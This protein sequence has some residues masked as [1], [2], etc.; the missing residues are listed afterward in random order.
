MPNLNTSHC[1]LCEGV[2]CSRFY[3]D[4]NKRRFLICTQCQLVYVMPEYLPCKEFELSEYQLHENSIQDEGY[5][6]FLQR[7]LTPLIQSYNISSSTN[8]IDYGCGPAPALA[9]ML[10]H[11]DV[12]DSI[13]DPFFFP[14]KSVLQ[15]QYDII[16]CTE[17]IEHFHAPHIEWAVWQGMLKPKGVIAIMTKR[18]IDKQRFA[19]WHYKNDLTHVSFFSEATF[20]FLAQRD[21]Y[22]VEF[23]TND[24]VLLKKV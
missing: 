16:T 1:P 7:L 6:R 13:Y 12:S 23:P 8:A 4:D 17:A 11:Y 9:T 15:Q 14:D 19:H 21:G 5:R 3:F 20:R 10:A 18:V 22:T 2:D 24:V